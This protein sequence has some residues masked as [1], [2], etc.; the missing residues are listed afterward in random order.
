MKLQNL[1]YATMVACA[2]S[3]CSNDD[4]PNIP[5]PAQELDATLTVAFNSVG[6]NGG[7]LRS[8]QTKA[9]PENTANATIKKIGI[10]VFNAGAMGT[11]AEG[12]SGMADGALISYKERTLV[13]GN[14]IDS[15][16]CVGAK[17]GYVDVLVVANPP[18][19][20]EGLK[21]KQDFIA[22]TNKGNADID[23]EAL[24]MSSKV[25]RVELK[26]GRNVIVKDDNDTK[27]IFTDKAAVDNFITSSGD[28]QVFRNVANIQLNT[29]KV[30]PRAD[31]GG[32]TNNA[33]FKL[34]K[35][36]VMH[37]LPSVRIFGDAD[38]VWCTVRDG[39]AT[40]TSNK[41]GTAMNKVYS[42]EG[43][44]VFKYEG[45]AKAEDVTDMP[46]FFVYDNSSTA[47]IND[48]ANVTALV[49]QGD[50]TYTANNGAVE[51]SEDAYWTV[52]INNDKLQ[53][54]T[55]AGFTGLEHCGVL[56]NVQYAI[57]ATITGT[58]SYDPENP[59]AAATLTAN[60]EVVPWGQ[61]TLD[62]SI[63]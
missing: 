61:L 27:Q 49:I 45:T 39:S 11:G 25:Y 55:A 4:D 10:A 6:S 12:A 35:V 59:S 43:Q 48:N 17:S 34:K 21:T 24:L 50:Y 52:Y 22:A 28:I 33:T 19:N 18:A 15:T 41:E 56:R 29:I 5:D 8:L 13:T 38:K 30:D 26:K 58:G 1:I 60:V 31:F 36:Y 20:L 3:A 46:S 53:A 62:P 16:D 2:F 37:Y 23:P 63:D 40:I 57:N 42:G 44:Q 51:T 14:D 9:G 54:P 32:T 7:G 47:I